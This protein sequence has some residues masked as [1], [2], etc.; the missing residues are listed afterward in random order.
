[1]EKKDKWLAFGVTVVVFFCA[2]LFQLDYRAI[3][4]EGMTLSSIV[5]AVYVAT[6]M[7]LVGSKLGEKLAETPSQNPEFTQLWVLRTYF[8]NAIFFAVL[9]IILSSVVLLLPEVNEEM[10]AYYFAG[11]RYFSALSLAVYA[12][13]LVFMGFTLKF[14]LNRQIWNV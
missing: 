6:M 5:L 3:A 4:S 10:A 13:N 7:G 8:S 12:V 14:M 11:Y 9:T 1:M 2:I